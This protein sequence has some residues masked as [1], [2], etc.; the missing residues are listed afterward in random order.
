MAPNQ[1]LAHNLDVFAQG[2]IWV[3]HSRASVLC[4]YGHMRVLLHTANPPELIAQKCV[5]SQLLPSVRPTS[6][7]SV[8][9]INDEKSK[10]KEKRNVKYSFSATQA[11]AILVTLFVLTFT[12]PPSPEYFLDL[13]GFKLLPEGNVWCKRIQPSNTGMACEAGDV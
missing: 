13:V 4:M 2:L 1:T 8:T 3:Y 10:Q 11:A 9:G 7:S 12:P 6:A 5:H